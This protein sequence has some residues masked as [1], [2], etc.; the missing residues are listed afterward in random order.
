MD[1]CVPVLD[2]VLIWVLEAELM[3]LKELERDTDD[4][5]ERMDVAAVVATLVPAPFPT[6]D[7]EPGLL[8]GTAV[9]DAEKETDA[10]VAVAENIEVD[11]ETEERRVLRIVD[12]TPVADRTD[13]GDVPVA[14]CVDV[15]GRVVKEELWLELLAWVVVL[16]EVAPEVGESEVL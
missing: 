2:A 11:D 14:C 16:D 15:M 1:D 9:D 7:V 10:L 6:E 13:E 3:E 8:D 5:W 12:V 4:P